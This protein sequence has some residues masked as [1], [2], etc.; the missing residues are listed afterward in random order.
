MHVNQVNEILDN[1][2]NHEG[3]KI[4]SVN[5]SRNA[6]FIEMEQLSNYKNDYCVSYDMVILK[7]Q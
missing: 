1:L 6:L 2:I 5:E 4:D 3:N 7:P